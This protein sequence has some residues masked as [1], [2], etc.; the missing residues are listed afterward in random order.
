MLVWTGL[1]FALVFTLNVPGILA[2]RALLGTPPILASIA[3]N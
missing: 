1:A 2:N 3:G